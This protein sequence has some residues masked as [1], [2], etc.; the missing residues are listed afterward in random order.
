[1][2]HCYVLWAK[3]QNGPEIFLAL[4]FKA[5]QVVGWRVI[6][7]GRKPSSLSCTDYISLENMWKTRFCH[8]SVIEKTMTQW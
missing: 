2:L 5:K 3:R 7:Q 4:K 8:F 6:K 1:M